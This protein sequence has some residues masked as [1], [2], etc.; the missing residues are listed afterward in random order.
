MSLLPVGLQP[1]ESRDKVG[2]VSGVASHFI[3]NI[4][5]GASST[6]IKCMNRQ[7][8]QKEHI[9]WQSNCQVIQQRQIAQESGKGKRPGTL[10]LSQNHRISELK[11]PWR[12]SAQLNLAKHYITYYLQCQIFPFL[13]NFNLWK[14][15]LHIEPK[16]APSYL[17]LLFLVLPSGI[18]NLITIAKMY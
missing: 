18:S 15:P 8:S 16:I 1:Q 17:Y 9:T 7:T 6:V 5:L 11:G 3:L 4:W 2:E 12:L 13:E 10:I 14:Y